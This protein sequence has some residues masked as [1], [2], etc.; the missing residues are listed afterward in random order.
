MYSRRRFPGFQPHTRAA[1]RIV[2]L[3]VV[4][5]MLC[6]AALAAS[7]V[8]EAHEPSS[9]IYFNDA[10]MIGDSI[11]D[12]V[13]MFDLFPSANF[14][15]KIGISPLSAARREFRY[16][17]SREYQTLYDVVEKYPHKKIYILLGSNSL[18]NKPSDQAYADYVPMVDTFQER[19]PDSL[20]YLI[21]PPSMTQRELERLQISPKRFAN[22]RDMLAALAEER[23]LYI[24]DFYS[25]L[26]NEKGYLPA[27][28]D[29]GDGIH[30]NLEGLKLLE[31]EIRT[32]TVP[33]QRTVTFIWAK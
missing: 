11:M 1:G 17:G 13:E 4:L 8:P 31:N 27:H 24:I 10:V 16:R 32:R 20:I 12:D 21:V 33:V 25:L 5:L 28:Y 15:T 29:C 9:D 14:V 2:S 26:L 22:F 18:D 23:G 6:P 3:L 19:F 7:P 30:P